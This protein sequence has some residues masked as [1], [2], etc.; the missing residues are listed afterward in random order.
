MAILLVSSLVLMGAVPFV[1]S[2]GAANF[3]DVQIFATTASPQTYNF[4]FSAYNLTGYL[5]SSY[6]T[7]YPAAA[8]ELP[9]GGY[10]FTVSATHF[11]SYPEYV[12][13]M[14]SG[15]SV[16]PAGATT[17]PPTNSSDTTNILPYPCGPPSSEYGYDTATITGPQTIDITMQNVT[18]LPTTKVTVNVTYMNGTAAADASVYASVVGEWYS[19]WWQSPAVVMGGQTNASGTAELVLPRAPAVVTAWKWIPVYV[20]KNESTIETTIGGQ[21]VNV[22]VYW[23]PT[24]I[25]LSG[26]GL[27]LPPQTHIG[28]T[29]SYQQPNYWVMP[30][31][32]A[33]SGAYAGGTPT[34][35]VANQPEGTPSLAQVSSSGAQSTSQYYLPSQIPSIEQISNPGLA[36]GQGWGSIEAGVT[37]TALIAATLVVIF[38]ATRHRN[39]G[40]PSLAG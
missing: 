25:G 2:A 11:G 13:P 24:Y 40:P 3:E 15:G 19:W 37:A 28:L 7:S 6:Q 12:C 1:Q 4:Q 34:A 22:T 20:P 26:S 35:T 9:P 21:K 32:V 31:G 16:Q 33:S 39:H 5:V 23:Q 30:A 8:F 10:M 17:P 29:L 38:V 14:E 27:L 36:S 18:Q